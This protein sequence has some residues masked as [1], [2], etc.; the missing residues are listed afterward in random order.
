ESV[1]YVEAHG[2][3]TTVGDVVEVSALDA[4][5]REQGWTPEGSRKA[6]LGSVKA[7]LGHTRSAA[8]AAGLIKAALS[9]HRGILTPQPSVSEQNPKLDLDSGPFFLPRK[10]RPWESAGPRRAGVSSFGFGGTNV[11]VVL[12]EAPAPRR[13]RIR[14]PGTRPRSELFLVSAPTAALLA[15]HAR[16]L[17]AAIER[18]VEA[19]G[20]E[21]H[22]RIGG[23]LRS[24]LQP[25]AKTPEAERKLTETQVCQPAMAAVA[26]ALHAFLGRLGVRGDVFLG[27]S[28]GEFVA[29]AAAGMMSPA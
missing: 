25:P 12:E 19:L 6:A 20:P 27:H 29:A 16:E 28:L 9:V 13:A 3:A 1:G 11:H 8:A 26:L 10:A 22:E 14:A 4:L 17:S 15:R 7:N 2:T 24:F 5:Y 18:L 23:T 21:L